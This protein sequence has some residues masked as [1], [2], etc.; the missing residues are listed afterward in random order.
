MVGPVFSVG[1]HPVVT[2]LGDK[3]GGVATAGS[4]SQTIYEH[5]TISSPVLES[6][7]LMCMGVPLMLSPS[8]SHVT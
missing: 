6:L 2:P 3:H 5:P 4:Q 1:W 7:L 8:S